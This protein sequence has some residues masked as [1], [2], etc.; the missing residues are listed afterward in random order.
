MEVT[1]PMKALLTRLP[2]P[3]GCVALGLIGLAT[4]LGGTSSL[5]LWLFGLCSILLQLL[6]FLKLCLPGQFRAACS[7]CV[8][9]STLAGYSMA[10]MLTAAQLKPFFPYAAA[11]TLWCCGLLLHLI[12]LILFSRK[13]LR[14]R[15]SLFAARGSWLLVYVGIAA[16]SISAPAFAAE[17]IGR[18]LLIPAA[19]GALILVPMILRAELCGGIPAGQKPLFCIIAAP[20]SIWICGYFSSAPACSKAL[21]SVLLPLSQLFYVLALWRLVKTFRQPFSPAFA[22]FTFPFVISATALKKSCAFLGCAGALRLLILLE[23]LIAAAGCLFALAGYL[24]FLL[25][26]RT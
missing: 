19:L 6:L 17:M 13:L 22:A 25:A 14:E 3:V 11:F 18:I 2:V 4:L 26:K 7:D 1:V 15:P 21:V 5:F 24:R 20:V 10:L 9:L 12:I 16:A 23:V 8:T